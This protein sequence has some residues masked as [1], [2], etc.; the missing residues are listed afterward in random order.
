M[1]N[2]HVSGFLPVDEQI[3]DINKVREDNVPNLK[4]LVLEYPLDQIMKITF[5]DNSNVSPP[6]NTFD[7]TKK[8]SNETSWMFMKK[9]MIN[10]LYGLR[11]FDNLSYLMTGTS[12]FY[13]HYQV[14]RQR[15]FGVKEILSK[16][17]DDKIRW[18]LQ[19]LAL[20]K[21]DSSVVQLYEELDGNFNKQIYLSYLFRWIGIFTKKLSPHDRIYNTTH[22]SEFFI[23]KLMLSAMFDKNGNL[24]S[25]SEWRD[26]VEKF[27]VVVKNFIVDRPEFAT[28]QF[29]TSD[30]LNLS[31]ENLSTLESPFGPIE[32]LYNKY[33]RTE[34]IFQDSDFEESLIPSIEDLF[35]L[36]EPSF[37]NFNLNFV[38]GWQI[39]A[40]KS[41]NVNLGD[42][43][44]VPSDEVD[45]I[46]IV[47]AENST[48][49]PSEK[50]RRTHEDL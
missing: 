41:Y 17:L 1:Q 38:E 48:N 35:L 36:N 13:Y 34:K 45:N 18:F 40:L 16:S 29:D 46:Q 19:E 21:P 47:D 8:I 11:K 44:S 25:R 12:L 5:D 10:E 32:K 33:R 43:I 30:F 20:V 49:G 6:E 22:N 15:G 14:M 23:K 9:V 4:A 28:P 2:L 27:M 50:E 37:Q 7:K 26:F 42:N 24:L 3:F 31:F 39:K